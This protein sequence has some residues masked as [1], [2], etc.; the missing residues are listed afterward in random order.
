MDLRQFDFRRLARFALLATTLALVAFAQTAPVPDN[1]A[2]TEAKQPARVVPNVAGVS[3]A[4]DSNGYKVESPDILAIRVWHQP[5]FSGA[6]SVHPDGQITM[7]LI[8]DLQAGGKTPAEIEKTVKEALAK[9]VKEPIV[10]V[11]VQNVLSKKYYM[12]GEI[13]RPGE[14]ELI[15]TTTIL[16]AISKAGGLAPFASE[17]KIYILRGDKRIPFN[18]KEVIHGKHLE[19]NITLQPGDHV[20]IP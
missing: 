17:K 12:D 9:Y 8:G 16:E 18:Y 11:T 13:N 20:V 6:Y 14:Y 3:A 5:D 15:S 4:V 19:Q 2:N 1:Q 7:P 10:T